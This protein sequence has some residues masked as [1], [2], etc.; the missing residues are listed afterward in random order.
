MKSLA[1]FPYGCNI[2]TFQC[3]VLHG[4]QRT[5]NCRPVYL[6]IVTFNLELIYF[7]FNVSN[8]GLPHKLLFFQAIYFGEFTGL[9]FFTVAMVTLIVTSS[10]NCSGWLL[11]YYEDCMT[12]PG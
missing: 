9:E 7:F 4:R 8:E 11:I 10:G 6:N 2:F 5:L 1:R 12:L 3:H